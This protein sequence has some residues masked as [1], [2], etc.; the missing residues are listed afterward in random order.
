MVSHICKKTTADIEPAQS[1]DLNQFVARG[2]EMGPEF[3]Y[4]IC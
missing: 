1:T 4:P 3:K 2:M